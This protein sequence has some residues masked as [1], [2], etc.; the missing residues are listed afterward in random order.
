MLRVID[1]HTGVSLALVAA[2][3]GSAIF[4]ASIYFMSLRNE[5]EIKILREMYYAQSKEDHNEMIRI[6]SR[7]SMIET[8]LQRVEDWC[9]ALIKRLEENDGNK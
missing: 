2:L 9:R 4:I 5:Q 3:L 6:E 8:K 7:L 1:E